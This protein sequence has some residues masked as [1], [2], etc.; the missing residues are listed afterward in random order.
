MEVQVETS[1]DKEVLTITNDIFTPVIA[2]YAEKNPE[3]MCIEAV[4]VNIFCQFFSHSVY[5]GYTIT[6]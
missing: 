1:L 3:K 5:R 6:R 4:A 2:K